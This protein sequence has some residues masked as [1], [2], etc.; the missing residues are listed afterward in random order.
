MLFEELFGILA[1]LFLQIGHQLLS[2]RR[3][4]T[5]VVRQ[6]EGDIHK[7]NVSLQYMIISYNQF[8]S[9]K[10]MCYTL[11]RTHKNTTMN[12]D[13]THMGPHA[14]A[15]YRSRSMALASFGIDSTTMTLYKGKE[16]RSLVK[17]SKSTRA[18]MVQQEHALMELE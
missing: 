5:D 4:S 8:D 2:G 7:N 3:V 11:Y 18:L 15:S 1:I 17:E 16:E 6:T 14:L 12:T 13:I 10:S 9:D